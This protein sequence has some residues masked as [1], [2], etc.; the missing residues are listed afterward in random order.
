MMATALLPRAILLD[1]DDTVLAFSEGADPCW[2]RI[3]ERF[4]L[5]IEGLSPEELFDA[6]KESRA[7]FWGDSDRHRR[8]RLRLDG[9]R[10]E[11]VA[12]AF[13]RLHI[14]APAL[15]NEIG[16]AYAL[17]RE[18]TIRPFSGA[19]ET[20]RQ[21]RVRGVRLALVTNGAAEIQRRKIDRFGLA[22]L[23]DCIVIEGE[24]GVGKP[25]ERV[26]RYA[27]DQLDTKPEETWMVGDNLE[28]EVRAPQRLGICGIW[29]DIAGRGLP[30]ASAIHPDRT[31]RSITELITEVQI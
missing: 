4:A 19:V 30:Q 22:S 18:D 29:L 28:W 1:L 25:D 13:D 3:C 17:E 6:I 11:I 12:E 21:L 15:V 20:L 24:F 31:I 27:L 16:D 5:R 2:R 10:R 9:A 8:G 26:Y 7:W 23:F 14:D